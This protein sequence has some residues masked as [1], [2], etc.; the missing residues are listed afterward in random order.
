MLKCIIGVNIDNK[1]K[2]S[3]VTKIAPYY[4]LLSL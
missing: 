1:A 4:N 3:N 2:Q